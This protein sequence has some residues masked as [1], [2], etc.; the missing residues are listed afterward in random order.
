MNPRHAVHPELGVQPAHNL[1]NAA[2]QSW[3]NPSRR[4]EGGMRAFVTVS[5]QPYAGGTTFSHRLAARLNEVIGDPPWSAWDRELVEKIACEQGI[6]AKLVEA[7]STHPHTWLDE[8]VEA[9]SASS[10][11]WRKAEFRLYK[12][13]AMAARALAHAGHAI[14]VGQGGVFVTGQMP[15]GVHIRLVAPL[16]RRISAMSEQLNIPLYEAADRMK[17]AEHNRDTFFKRYWPGR[18]L[19]GESFTMTLNSGEM[20]VDDLVECVLPMVLRREQGKSTRAGTSPEA[21]ELSAVAGRG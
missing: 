20:N 18:K 3:N 5:R 21:P 14:L 16:H 6:D 1:L 13:V 17:E 4:A 10:E 7:I 12:H 2:I 15:G 19:D 11:S 9:I 8:L